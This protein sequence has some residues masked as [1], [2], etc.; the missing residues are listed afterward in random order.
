MVVRVI[1]TGKVNPEWQNEV[2][3]PVETIA[4]IV[5]GKYKNLYSKEDIAGND[6]RPNDS[7]LQITFK[8]GTQASFGDEWVLKFE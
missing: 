4:V 1:R 6:V 2:T 8:D 5:H 3:Y 7:C